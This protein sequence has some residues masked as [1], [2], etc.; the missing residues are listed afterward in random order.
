MPLYNKVSCYVGDNACYVKA[1]DG[2][3]DVTDGVLVALQE[4]LEIPADSADGSLDAVELNCSLTAFP[5]GQYSVFTYVDRTS[6]YDLYLKEIDGAEPIVTKTHRS[7]GVVVPDNSVADGSL[8]AGFLELRIS[9]PASPNDRT[10]WTNTVGRCVALSLSVMQPRPY[11]QGAGPYWSVP[12]NSGLSSEPNVLTPETCRPCGGSWFGQTVFLEPGETISWFGVDIGALESSYSR[13]RVMF[14]DIDYEETVPTRICTHLIDGTECECIYDE[15]IVIDQTTCETRRIPII[16]RTKGLAGRYTEYHVADNSMPSTMRQMG[17]YVFLDP[18]VGLDVY[19]PI[20]GSKTTEFSKY[21][22]RIFCGEHSRSQVGETHYFANVPHKWRTELVSAIQP[23]GPED[24]PNG[25]PGGIDIVNPEKIASIYKGKRIPADW[26]KRI[27]M[28]DRKLYAKYYDADGNVC[29]DENK[30]IDGSDNLAPFS[31][32]NYYSMWEEVVASA[33]DIEPPAIA[34][35]RLEAAFEG[36]VASQLVERLCGDF[37]PSGNEAGDKDIVLGTLPLIWFKKIHNEATATIVFDGT[38]VVAKIPYACA[39]VSQFG[40]GMALMCLEHV[41]NGDAL[42]TE[43]AH[44]QVYVLEPR[45]EQA[46]MSLQGFGWGG[47]GV[48]GIY[49]QS[50]GI[51]Y[52]THND[53]MT[54]ATLVPYLPNIFGTSEVGSEPLQNQ[55]SVTSNTV[56]MT[57]PGGITMPTSGSAFVPSHKEQHPLADDKDVMM[58]TSQEMIKPN[59]KDAKSIGQYLAVKPSYAV[60]VNVNADKGGVNKPV[61]EAEVKGTNI[62]ER[63]STPQMIDTP[64]LWRV[65]NMES[66]VSYDHAGHWREL[67][68]DVGVQSGV[69]LSGGIHPF[70]GLPPGRKNETHVWTT[71]ATRIEDGLKHSQFD[72]VPSK[73]LIANGVGVV[74]SNGM[75]VCFTQNG[76]TRYNIEHFGPG[77]EDKAIVKDE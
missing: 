13:W 57:F 25:E 32:P 3:A 4:I 63:S 53:H 34:A 21:T 62:S 5:C 30:L 22:G 19:D 49:P 56:L 26:L 72:F 12:G 11:N 43:H 75:L 17:E 39:G 42:M 66:P 71:E 69:P 77:E 45:K 55:S 33:P 18:F 27:N 15:E 7:T 29:T 40:N 28:A 67:W 73:P 76:A 60:V 23:P 16:W 54:H 61:I 52:S 58:E 44:L 68:A 74:G 8:S 9:N 51:N 47:A 46:T 65:G 41:H 64:I 14:A 70:N 10:S 37:T 1:G 2:Y 31:A 36:G 20:P 59:T 50:G 38:K 35:K 24:F 48:A 6:K